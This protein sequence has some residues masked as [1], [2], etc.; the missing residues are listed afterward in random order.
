[1]S[2]PKETPRQKMIGMMYL[3]LTAMLAL[4]VSTEVLKS[5]ITVNDAMEKTNLNYTEKNEALYDVFQRAYAANEAKVAEQWAKAQ[6]VRAKSQE[7]Y[8]YIQQTKYE[9]V[10][11]TEGV[12]IEEAKT[13]HPSEFGKQDNYDIPTNFFLGSEILKNGR[14]YI[15]HD[16]ID[17]Y[18]TFLLNALGKDTSKVSLKSL[19]VDGDYK[20][21]SGTPV[22]WETFNFSH[23]IIVADLA[24]LNR[25]QTNIRNAESD[26]VSQLY[27]SVSED[28]FKFDTI[29]A[30]VVP[31]TSNA[32]VGS[33]FEA[34][35]FVAA[36]DSRSKITA[37]ING[38]TY[39]GEAGS[40][41]YRIPST[42][43]G[44]KVLRGTI[45]VPSTFGIKSY[46]FEY[47]YNVSEPMATVSADAMNVLYMGVNNPISA[48]AAGVADK[49]IVIELE[50]TK[51]AKLIRKKPGSNA[52]DSIYIRSGANKNKMVK[53]NIYAN[54]S[55]GRKLMGS[56]EFRIKETPLPSAKLNGLSSSSV[57]NVPLALLT[58]PQ[59]GLVVDMPDFDLAIPKG[60]LRIISF[61]VQISRGNQL[62][63]VME[64]NGSRFSK[65]MVENFRQC[66]PG[67]K[68]YF[69]DIQ[70]ETL[71]GKE[72]LNDYTITID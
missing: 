52:S 46:P 13:L 30:R 10:A 9:V 25:L 45:D 36:F 49:D 64:S 44:E 41:R 19:E 62:G 40:I 68:V 14:A 2:A 18:R 50:D 27:S 53:I 60:K 59:G 22:D 5:F 6:E 72:R 70:A 28:D 61:K 24:L 15:L 12:T 47:T 58:H 8:D 39:E 34:D 51:D 57:Q 42:S 31:T 1:M 7:L 29:S 69:Q 32:V 20:D 4:N 71:N 66:S 21:A 11:K 3:V 26:V 33:D 67:N 54:S 17:E 35:I 23:T 37:T 56:K 38:K 48:I 63:Y 16:K 43:A 65:D 55:Q